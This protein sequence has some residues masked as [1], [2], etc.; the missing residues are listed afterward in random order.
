MLLMEYCDMEEYTRTLDYDEV[1]AALEQI[2]AA[3]GPDF[4]YKEALRPARQNGDGTACANWDYD[5]AP[6]CIVGHYVV[7]AGIVEPNTYDQFSAVQA[8]MHS[9]GYGMDDATSILLHTVQTKQDQGVSWGDSLALAKA[10]VEKY[11]ANVQE[12]DTVKVP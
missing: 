7:Q 12:W 5:G 10:E 11:R 6:S 9:N 8:L 1:L 3:K 2:V 4:V